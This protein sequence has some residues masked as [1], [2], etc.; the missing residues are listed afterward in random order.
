M[1]LDLISC[2][3]GHSKGSFLVTLNATKSIHSRFVSFAL[4]RLITL[5][6]GMLGES[7]YRQFIPT[8]VEYFDENT[9]MTFDGK[10]GICDHPFN[11]HGEDAPEYHIED[12]ALLLDE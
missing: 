11:R 12:G 3:I 1:V 6:L 10:Q 5:Q 7:K 9:K 8:I 2:S 4:N